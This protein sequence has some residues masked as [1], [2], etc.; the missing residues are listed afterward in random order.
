MA[1]L[2][3]L[4]G[5]LEQPLNPSNGSSQ[6]ATRDEESLGRFSF[7]LVDPAAQAEFEPWTDGMAVGFRCKRN[8]D[9]RAEYIYLL[10]SDGWTGD[11]GSVSLLRGRT[12]VPGRDE[13]VHCYLLGV[14][15][16][17]AANDDAPRPDAA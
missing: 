16:P 5:V 3:A 8:A 17:P 11:V 14:P 2:R 4:V 12:G 13:L 10:P 9:E 15:A 7:T 6:N 1:A